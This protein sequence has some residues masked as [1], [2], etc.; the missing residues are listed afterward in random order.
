MLHN[1]EFRKVDF[2]KF[3]ILRIKSR[4]NEFASTSIIINAANE[5]LVDQ[6]LQKNIRFSDIN[7]IIMAVLKDRNYRK[8]AIRKPINVKEIQLV[9]DWARE[10]TLKKYVKRNK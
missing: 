2:R 8:Y 6:F 10:L 7:K 9:N 4:A 3:T 1:L 5:I